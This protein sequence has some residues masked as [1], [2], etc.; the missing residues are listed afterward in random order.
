MQFHTL[1]DVAQR[2]Q[3]SPSTVR[4]YVKEGELQAVRFK[5]V[6][7]FRDNDIDAFERQHVTGVDR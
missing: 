4:R 5:G 3:L 6:L 1:N 2:W 7:R